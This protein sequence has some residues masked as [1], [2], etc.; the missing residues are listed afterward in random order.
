[1]QRARQTTPSPSQNKE[2]HSRS[3]AT[4]AAVRGGMRIACADQAA[5]AA[6]VVPGLPLADARALVPD[7]SV[8]DAD[9]L[10]DPR[11]LEALADWCTLYAPLSALDGFGGAGLWLD[12]SGCAH[13]FGGEEHLLA[14]LG[15][16]L[17]GFGYEPVLAAAS[18]PGAAW[19]MAR[20]GNRAH[21][22][23]SGGRSADRVMAGA[24]RQTLGSL[25]VA[26]LRL[27][28]DVCEGLHRLGIR[29]IGDLLGMAPGPL[30]R[31]FG[32]EPLHRL[33][34]A[35]GIEDEAIEFRH[36]P[37]PL[38][39]RKAFAE[40]IGRPED[41]E[42]ALAVLLEQA[43]GRLAADDRGVRR[44]QLACWRTDGTV[45][46]LAIG[47][48]RAVRDERHLLRL[49]REKLDRLDAGFGIEAMVLTVPATAPLPARQSPLASVSKM[50]RE[51]QAAALAA[52]IDRVDNKLGPGSVRRLQPFPSHVPE[53]AAG[54]VP[55]G[56]SGER[57]GP[58]LAGAYRP[59]SP[60]PVRPLVRPE[61]IDV[62][63]PVPDHPPLIFRWQRRRYQ[64]VHAEGPE[65]IA[66]EWWRHDP[67]LLE[68]DGERM[69]DYYRVEDS[70]GRRFWVFRAGSYEAGTSPRWYLHGLFG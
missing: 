16:R 57:D 4:V 69:R 5:E 6:G 40:P 51:K 39:F 15:E 46:R 7:L 58:T 13:L 63:A 20:F 29:R 21:Q 43:C 60:R 34:Q 41:V 9:P 59:S 47:T 18:T 3:L 11:A 45:R 53:R 36:P 42:A 35:L 1:M 37:P 10:A 52:F 8:C 62:M 23:G 31:R 14:D 33:D 24:E 26:A 68:T 54:V 2:R 38:W 48:G 32:A 22:D 28:T 55:V 19:A 17:R 30:A 67:D 12:I 61:P 27:S 56:F 64:V 70:D 66:S 44:L 65:R 49:F 25:P 50:A